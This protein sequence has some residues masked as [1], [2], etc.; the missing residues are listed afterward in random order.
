MW[1][2]LFNGA[3]GA[4]RSFRVDMGQI[5][6]DSSYLYRPATFLEDFLTHSIF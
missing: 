5:I 3:V 2:D 4:I 6:F 1:G